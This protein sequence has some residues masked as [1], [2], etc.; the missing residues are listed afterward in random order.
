M[1]DI[2][3]RKKKLL[4]REEKLKKR[5]EEK[6]KLEELKERKRW[7]EYK[8]LRA[9]N[10]KDKIERDSYEKENLLNCKED[11][12][13]IL[14]DY[15]QNIDSH[16][17]K[18]KLSEICLILHGVP[19]SKEILTKH[20]LY[21]I[22]SG[23]KNIIVCSYSTCID[24]E[25]YKHCCII[26]NDKFGNKIYNHRGLEN[27]N[28]CKL[29]ER[30]IFTY[31]E[32]EIID[33][34]LKYRI[35]SPTFFITLTSIRRSLKK[36]KET[37]SNCKY[38]FRSRMDIFYPYLNNTLLYLYLIIKSKKIKND[39]FEYRLISNSL[40][41]EEGKNYDKINNIFRRKWRVYS[42]WIFGYRDDIFDYYM[43]NKLNVGT[44]SSGSAHVE[45]F[46]C[47]SYI[48][49]RKINISYTE[50]INKYF[51]AY[52]NDMQVGFITKNINLRL[53]SGANCASNI[54]F[55]NIPS[56][57]DNKQFIKKIQEY[58]EIQYIQIYKIGEGLRYG[59]AKFM[60]IEDKYT[61]LERF[62]EDWVEDNP[63]FI[64][65]LLNKD[66]KNISILKRKLE[67]F[68]EV[69]NLGI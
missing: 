45:G 52:K 34:I 12:K 65:D 15:P 7:I 14:N 67:N 38:I 21:Y 55:R 23:I 69:N 4:K 9:Q 18:Q 46:F 31:N 25:L 22:N 37:F 17:L 39:I 54:F 49:Q 53:I 27:Y 51:Y 59:F 50:A 5:R 3:N 16:L 20:V 1:V 42:S 66:S 2:S 6:K 26:N 29:N 8:K 13:K 19:K 35:K 36:V 60:Y 62:S 41:N 58:G 11:I 43:F 64:L 63:E 32:E 40:G 68:M 47:S 56:K 30:Y 57:L 24:E 61:F 33:D 48:K 28:K 10:I 44:R